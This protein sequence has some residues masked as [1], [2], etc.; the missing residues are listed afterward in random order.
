MNRIKKIDYP[1]KLQ[2]EW[3]H[4]YNFLLWHKES[5]LTVLICL[6]HSICECYF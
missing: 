4:K 5:D 6:N 3:F 2:D 1:D